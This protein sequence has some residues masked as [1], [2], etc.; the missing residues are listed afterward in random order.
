MKYD[1]D[2]ARC[3]RLYY[4]WM[5]I[6]TPMVLVSI[7]AVYF[8]MF[9]ATHT[10]IF[11]YNLVASLWLIV[12]GIWSFIFTHN[13]DFLKYAQDWHDLSI[14]AKKTE[15]LKRRIEGLTGEQI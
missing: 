7:F 8:Y 9:M 2:E 5:Y 3:I 12:L 6:S 10:G 15:E 11:S 4:K 14:M 1:E 13:D